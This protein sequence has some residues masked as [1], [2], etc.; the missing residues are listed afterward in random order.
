[1]IEGV[2]VKELVQYADERGFFQEVVRRTDP[3]FAAGFGQL[4]HS[5]V[6]PGGV[7]AWHAHKYQAQWTY[8][9]SGL[10]KI[11]IHDCRPD[12][13]TYRKTMELLAG[14]VR[15]PLVYSLPPGVAHGYR[16][17]DG[18]AHVLYVTSGVYDLE[19]EIRIPHDDSGIGYDWTKAAPIK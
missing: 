12:S 3:F 14:N 6:Y 4:S 18:P 15:K 13:P 19:D 16:C 17:I 2:I 1:M 5:L 8:V 11:A 10:L 7:K 9:A